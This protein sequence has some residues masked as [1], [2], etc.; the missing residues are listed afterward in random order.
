MKTKTSEISFY[1]FNLSHSVIGCVDG[2]IHS[3]FTLCL[4]TW[5][6]NQVKAYA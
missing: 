5:C 4:Y 1:C 3:T 6:Y 2:P